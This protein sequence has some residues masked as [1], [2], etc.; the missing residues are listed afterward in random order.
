[1]LATLISFIL[2][3]TFRNIIIPILEKSKLTF[4][5]TFSNF[6]K[7][8]WLISTGKERREGERNK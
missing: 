8:T 4:R 7:G 2:L 1:M 5:K 6:P 3:R